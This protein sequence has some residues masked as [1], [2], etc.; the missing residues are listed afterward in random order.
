MI[1]PGDDQSGMLETL[2]CKSFEESPVDACIDEFIACAR[3]L[4]DTKIQRLD[5]ARAHAYLATRPLPHVSVGVAA[6]KAIGRSVMTYLPMC[7]R[8]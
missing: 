4:P 3:E 7:G 8:S 6:E 1:L 2:L 5:K